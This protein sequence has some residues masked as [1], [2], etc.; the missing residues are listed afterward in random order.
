MTYQPEI[1]GYF[2]E[3]GD[4]PAHDPGVEVP[5]PGCGLPVGLDGI[6][7]ISFMLPGSGRSWFYRGHKACL[8]DAVQAHVEGVIIDA[9]AARGGST[10]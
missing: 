5:C 2:T 10:T 1:Y 6:S 3:V 9:M 7:S 8:T 4:T